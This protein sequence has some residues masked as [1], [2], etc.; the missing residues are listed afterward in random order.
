MNGKKIKVAASFTIIVVVLGWLVIS[1]FDS[2]H[3]RYYVE[4]RELKAMQN[5]ASNGSLAVKGLK[6]KGNLVS[7]SLE[8]NS[9]SLEKIFI[10][11]EKDENLEVH[12]KGL[13]PDTFKDGAEVLVEGNYTTQGYFEAQKVMAKCPSKYETTDMY[14]QNYKSSSVKEKEGTF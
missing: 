2:E 12:Y 7:G 10:I 14:D 9:S 8:E 13:L 6:V 3:M 1:G 11:S 4:I 5:G